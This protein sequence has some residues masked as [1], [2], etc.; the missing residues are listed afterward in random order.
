MKRAIQKL[1]GF[2]V[3]ENPWMDEVVPTIQLSEK[4]NVSPEF[5]KKVNKWYEEMFG[6]KVVIFKTQDA[7]FMHPNTLRKIKQGINEQ[8]KRIG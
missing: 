2:D 3:F 5:R 8:E 6:H 7:L 4:V 1:N